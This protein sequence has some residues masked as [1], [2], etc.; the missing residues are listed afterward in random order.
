MRKTDCRH[1]A[2]PHGYTIGG[3]IEGRYI[4]ARIHPRAMGLVRGGEHDGVELLNKWRRPQAVPVVPEEQ[5]P[6]RHP[7]LAYLRLEGIIMNWPPNAVRCDMTKCSR[8]LS[9]RPPAD[10][11]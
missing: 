1:E 3:G 11:R 10:G 4:A 7:I 6:W 2:P 8:S 9:R 5:P